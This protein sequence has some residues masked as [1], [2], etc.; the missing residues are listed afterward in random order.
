[1]FCFSYWCGEVRLGAAEVVVVTTA[2]VLSPFR[3]PF[4]M[5]LARDFIQGDYLACPADNADY[6]KESPS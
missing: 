3:C 5:T 2:T 4:F 6:D 1:M